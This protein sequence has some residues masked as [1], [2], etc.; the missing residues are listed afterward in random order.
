MGCLRTSQV[1]FDPFVTVVD[2]ATDEEHRDAAIGMTAGSRLL[3]VV[4][5]LR[6]NEVF[7]IISARPATPAERR[8][9][10]NP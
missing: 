8:R 6:E 5:A 3:V 10:E 9:Y 2:A 1:F 7:R 4:H